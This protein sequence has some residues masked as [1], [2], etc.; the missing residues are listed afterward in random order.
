MKI[1]IS[2]IVDDKTQGFCTREVLR[3]K[4]LT[5][6][7]VQV[8]IRP[9]KKGIFLH[10]EE[11]GYRVAN[12]A[13][14][15]YIRL[16]VSAIEPSE[17][18]RDLHGQ[19]SWTGMTPEFANKIYGRPMGIPRAENGDHYIGHRQAITAIPEG[20]TPDRGADM[21]FRNDGTFDWKNL[22]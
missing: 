9:L 19:Y 6:K 4:K 1:V 3:I 22:E 5:P 2:S 7:E 11:P 16:V 13:A 20:F 8:Y 17:V 21:K 10:V 12:E 14:I 15:R 18:D